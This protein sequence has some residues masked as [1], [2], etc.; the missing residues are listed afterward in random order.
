MKRFGAVLVLL[1]LFAVSIASARDAVLTWTAPG[2]DG[3]AGRATS[4]DLR[5]KTVPIS[6]ADTT[7]WF[8]NAAIIVTLSPSVAGARDSVVMTGL[9]A[10][11]DYYF[12]LRAADEV[13]N[14]SFYSNVV[15]LVALPAPDIVRPST[16]WDMGVRPR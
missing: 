16:I 14:W 3:M 1:A 5:Y 12:C 4:Y 10:T 2:D 8:A 11:R 9:D 7:A 15:R 6:G 13:P